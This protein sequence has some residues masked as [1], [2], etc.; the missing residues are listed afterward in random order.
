MIGIIDTTNSKIIR[1]FDILSGNANN[2][3]IENSNEIV[4]MQLNQ[5]E[6]SNERKLCFI[7]LNRDMFL[8]IVNKP[9][10]IKIASM[11]DAF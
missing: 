9:E 1:I 6:I 8:T 5:T 3:N 2:I 11:V 10:I 7:D 4:A